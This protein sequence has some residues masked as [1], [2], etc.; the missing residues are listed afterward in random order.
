MEQEYIEDCNVTKLYADLIKDRIGDRKIS[1]YAHLYEDEY[2]KKSKFLNIDFDEDNKGKF[3]ALASLT[4]KGIAM[5]I[6]R[7]C[8]NVEKQCGEYHHDRYDKLWDDIVNYNK[9]VL[10]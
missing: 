6:N 3:L 2:K 1:E 5:A 10:E 9:K 8:L 7:I 4:E